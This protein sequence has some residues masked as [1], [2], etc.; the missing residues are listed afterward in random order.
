[1]G[2]K[3]KGK[4]TVNIEKHSLLSIFRTFCFFAQYLANKLFLFNF[5]TWIWDLFA[6][7]WYIYCSF[8]D[9]TVNPPFA[10]KS[11]VSYAFASDVCRYVNVFECD[12]HNFS[13]DFLSDSYI[14]PFPCIFKTTRFL[15]FFHLCIELHVVHISICFIINTN[16]KKLY[17]FTQ[18]MYENHTFYIVFLQIHKRGVCWG[19]HGFAWFHTVEVHFPRFLCSQCYSQP[20]QH[21]LLYPQ[22]SG[23]RTLQYEQLS[24]KW[25]DEI[26]IFCIRTHRYWNASLPKQQSVLV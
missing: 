23:Q 16:I 24:D 11:R 21:R 12:L 7:F 6:Y 5:A 13:Y 22:L 8:E 10:K 17:T 20:R 26:F 15:N 25:V 14:K 9:A 4:T 2:S 19:G 3:I 1:M 18:C